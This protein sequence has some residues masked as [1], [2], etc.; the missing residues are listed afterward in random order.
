MDAN[1]GARCKY[2]CRSTETDEHKD[3]CPTKD[4]GALAEWER[5]YQYGFEDNFVPYWIIAKYSPAFRLG[6]RVGKTEIDRLV[7][8]VI[9][10]RNYYGEH[11]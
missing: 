8:Q 1:G 7:E 9:E 10:E 5:G 11:W 6:Y 2:C 3:G 4:A